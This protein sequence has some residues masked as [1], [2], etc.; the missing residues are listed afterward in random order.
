MNSPPEAYAILAVLGGALAVASLIGFLLHLRSREGPS[1]GV[2]DNLNAR[3]RAWWVIVAVLGIVFLAGRGAVILLF[4]LLSFAAMREFITLA[5]TRRGDRTPLFA[6][7]LI[8]LPVQYGLIAIGWYGLFA[9]FIPVYGFLVLPI[10]AAFSADTRNFLSR[11]AETQWGLMISVY[12]ISYVPALLTLSIPGFQQRTMLLAAFLLIVVQSSDVLQYICG[13]LAGRHLIVPA[14]SPSKTVE[15][16]IGGVAGATLLGAALWRIT[17]FSPGQA[18]A[19]ALVI[20]LT[21][22]LGARHVGNQA[23]PVRQGL[24]PSARRSRRNAGPHGLHL[25]FR[26]HLLPSDALFLHPLTARSWKTQ[27]SKPERLLLEF[28]NDCGSKKPHYETVYA[29]EGR[30][31]RYHN[32]SL[33]KRGPAHWRR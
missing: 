8:V 12:C 20:A 2:I 5:S 26:S 33:G 14:L 4:A 10:L 24:E 30:C 21:G 32:L 29:F 19:M 23:R 27:Q 18:A 22:F 25:L 11:A 7:L 3:I 31:L 28:T 15:G 16:S 6:S 1:T 17:P 9:I 13:K